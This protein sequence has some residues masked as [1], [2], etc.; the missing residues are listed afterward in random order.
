MLFPLSL[1]LLR[2]LFIA[3][4]AKP[5]QYQ[6][7]SGYLVVASVTKH[8]LNVRN[9]FKRNVIQGAAV[10]ATHMVMILRMNVKPLLGAAKLQL[11]HDTKFGQ[12]FEVTVNG[13]QADAR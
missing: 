4:W 12:G 7:M 2:L 11:A 13:A 8:I 10:C 5:N 6:L 1:C 3:V 9:W